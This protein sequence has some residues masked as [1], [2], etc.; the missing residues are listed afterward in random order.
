MSA[1]TQE[2]HDNSTSKYITGFIISVVLTIASFAPIM[3]GWL[4][5]WSISAKVIYLLGLAFIQMAVQ[6]VFFLHLSDGPD[7]KWN[8][9]SMWITVVG[10]LV[11]IF[12][13]WWTMF[14]LNYNMMGGSGRVIQTDV[15]YPATSA[16]PAAIAPAAPNEA[17][18][19]SQSEA[20][21]Q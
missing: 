12:G 9:T 6:I 11:I 18:A 16:A 19:A 21:A 8:I 3:A 5:E 10:V 15:I 7:S 13:T 20:P 1:H 4:A 14:H 17:P 2:N